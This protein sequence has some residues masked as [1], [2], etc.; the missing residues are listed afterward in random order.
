MHWLLSGSL[1]VETVSVPIRGLPPALQGL[2]LVQLSDFHY[3]GVRLSEAMLRAVIARTNALT[4]DLVVLTGDF[5]TQEP[6]PIYTLA[7]KLRQIES[8]YG[9]YAILGNHDLFMPVSRQ[10]I[11]QAL[12]RAKIQVLWN[13]IAYPVG[14]DLPLV[15]M[16]D[17]W[18]GDFHP[19][20]VFDQLDPDL[21][22]LVLSHNPDTAAVLKP[23]RVDLQLSG[24]THGGQIVLPG[25]GAA[26]LVLRRF[27]PYVPRWMREH[28]PFMSDKCVRVVRHWEWAQ[29][30]HRVGENWLY[31]NRGLGTYAPG[32][33]FCPPELT[34]LT[35]VRA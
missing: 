29:G 25:L 18:S 5:V 8:R 19:T 16:A 3:D 23:W 22:R 34:L 20:R 10:V 27:R 12:E 17:F 35:L 15:G 32:R 11:T 24:H 13:A 30:L 7:R 9:T 14:P 6:E 2:R 31:V 21:P 1:T 28:I 33:F 4:P 26:P